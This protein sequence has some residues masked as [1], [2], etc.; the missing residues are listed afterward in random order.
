M[1]NEF[2]VIAAATA[3]FDDYIMR[4]WL[5]ADHDSGTPGGHWKDWNTWQILRSTTNWDRGVPSILLDTSG[6]SRRRS[7]GRPR[8]NFL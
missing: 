7:W 4:Q 6:T 3:K 2:H 8:S 1:G 5:P